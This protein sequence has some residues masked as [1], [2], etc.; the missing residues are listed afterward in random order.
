[1]NELELISENAAI[2]TEGLPETTS[3]ERTWAALVHLSTLFTLLISLGTLGIGGILFVFIPLAVY[4]FYKEKSSFVAYHAAQAFA[5]QMLCSIGFFIALLASILA[6]VVI[7]TVTGVL[8]IILVGLILVPL[9]L[10]ITVILPVVL[11]LLP[12]L[13]G[14][15][16]LVAGIQ[17]GGGINYQYPYIGR[18]VESWLRELDKETEP[19][20][21]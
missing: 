3:E 9:A 4:V 8:S 7:W 19:V 1:M 6:I 14:A 5:L 11:M 2:V 18:W 16:A 17:T 20:V 10:L 15:L 21:L 12:F 13:F